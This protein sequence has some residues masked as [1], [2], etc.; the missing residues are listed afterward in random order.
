M[1]GIS[2]LVA[3]A[4]STL[5]APSREKRASSPLKVKIEMVGNSEVKAV[6]KNEGQESLKVLK[7]GSIL[8]PVPVEKATV[9]A[10]DQPIEFEGI[11]LR[12]AL[13]ALSENHFQYILPGQSVETAFDLA[14]VHNLTSGGKFG[15]RVDG[16]FAFAK[17][18][19]TKLIGSIPY[20]SNHIVA[21]IDGSRAASSSLASLAKR[22]LVQS[23]CNGEKYIITRKALTECASMARDARMAASWGPA[24]KMEEYFQ[25]SSQEVRDTV[26][27][28]FDR[29][30]FECGSATGGIAEYY[31]TDVFNKCDGGT[32]AYTTPAR[33]KMFF[34]PLYFKALPDLARGCHHQDQAT[35]NIH[36][37]THLKR[38]KGTKDYGG[39]GYQFIRSLTPE[40]NLNHA[41]TYALFASAVRQKC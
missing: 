32:L 35:T 28:V 29:V 20:I 30:A 11:Q 14:D 38:I 22:T 5:A 16:A 8:S 34:C 15:V 33:G 36:E 37:V 25:S 19:S 9:F 1:K 23:D 13:G 4:A 7:T 40:Q 21:D 39:Y 31:C 26:S 10:D 27:G 18:N 24:D 12:I 17:D 6:I 3:L 2:V 41:D